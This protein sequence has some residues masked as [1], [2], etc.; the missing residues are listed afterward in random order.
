MPANPD[1]DD[2][3]TTTLRNRSGKAVDNATSTTV[4]LDRA[5]RKGKIKRLTGGR[6]IVRELEVGLNTGAGWY[7]G[8]D[9]LSTA[10]FQPFTAAEYDWKQAYSPCVW[11]G[12]EKRMN[13]GESQV[14]ALITGR[15]K[16]SEKSLYEVVAEGYYS[17][18]TGAGGKQLG[19]LNLGVAASPS[20]GTV[21][22]INRADNEFWRNQTETVDFDTA[23]NFL[24][25]NPSAFLLA[26]N[27]LAIECVRGTDRPDLWIFDA[28]GYNRY[29]TSLQPMQQITSTE[30]A[31]HGFTALKYFGAGQSSDV[32]LDNGY[33]P[34]KT[35]FALNTDYCYLEVHEEMD[36][37]PMGGERVPINQ[38]ATVR[39][40][41]FMGELTFSNLA[42]QGR[43]SDS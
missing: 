30:M 3:V 32:A 43:L 22:G 20:T 35:G 6:T 7:S 39:F 12:R 40:Y 11:S 17:D 28:I 8:Y 1:F 16:N 13:M 41:G 23:I 38:D 34:S 15:I 18:G 9:T 29:L 10:P 36:F 25:A 24:S 26:M 31:G 4:G 14:I 27:T 19:G 33:C 37:E 42:R 2:V 5:R 21:G